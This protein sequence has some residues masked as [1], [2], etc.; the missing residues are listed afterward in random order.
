LLANWDATLQE[1]RVHPLISLAAFNLDFLCI[2][3]FRDGNGRVSRLLL[4]LQCYHLEY[5]VGRYISLE[6]LIEQHKERYY[7]T[8]EA[9]SK[10]WHEA[11]HDP[12]PHINFVLYMLKLAYAEFH[13]RMEGARPPRGEKTALVLQAVQQ[14]TGP[15]RL[16]DLQQQCPG[17]SIDLIRRV[18]KNLRSEGRAECLGRGQDA[19]WRKLGSTQFNG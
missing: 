18:L 10:R 5:Q 14:A 19:R 3:P 2:H 13:E 17:V 1:R 7:E 6:R 4:L 12:W 8:L 15:F 16:A 9:S 11:R